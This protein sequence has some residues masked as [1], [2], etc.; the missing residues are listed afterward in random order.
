MEGHY[1]NSNHKIA[2][3]T[4]GK[5]AISKALDR[6]LAKQIICIMVD[7]FS[8]LSRAYPQKKKHLAHL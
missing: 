3:F 5:S 4:H 7:I 1:R 8:E 2:G 6:G